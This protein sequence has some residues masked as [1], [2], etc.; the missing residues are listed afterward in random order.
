[1]PSSIGMNRESAH[2]GREANIFLQRP[3][4]RPRPISR[5]RSR[6]VRS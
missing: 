6:Q 4:C 1:L 5:A 3:R 2:S